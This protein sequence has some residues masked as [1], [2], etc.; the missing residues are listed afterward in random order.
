MNF[1]FITKE[2]CL[3]FIAFYILSFSLTAQVKKEPRQPYNTVSSIYDSCQI[4]CN[5]FP[6][7][8]DNLVATERFVFPAITNNQECFEV[9]AEFN[10][11]C[12]LSFN[13]SKWFLIKIVKGDS[14]TFS[15]DNSNNYD[16]DAA[17]WGPIANNDLDSTCLATTKFPVT[18]DYSVIKPRFKL[19]NPLI[20]GYYI[21]V[22]SNYSN[23]NTD[24]LLNQP[25]GGKVIYSYFCSENSTI[26]ANISGKQNIQAIS[27]LKLSFE[28]SSSSYIS[29]I[30][31]NSIELLPGFETDSNTVFNASIGDCINTS[32]NYNPT[33]SN[34]ICEDFTNHKALIPHLYA[35]SAMNELVGTVFAKSQPEYMAYDNIYKKMTKI[36]IDKRNDRFYWAYREPFV[37]PANVKLRTN[38]GCPIYSDVRS[39]N[40]ATT[41][42][43]EV[44]LPNLD[45]VTNYFNLNTPFSCSQDLPYGAST[46]DLWSF[47]MSDSIPYIYYRINGGEWKN[48]VQ[49]YKVPDPFSDR[50]LEVSMI[51]QIR[52]PKDFIMDFSTDY[53]T[54]ID[55]YIVTR[56][57]TGGH[58]TGTAVFNRIADSTVIVS[59]SQGHIDV[60]MQLGDFPAYG[61]FGNTFHLGKMAEGDYTF[62]LKSIK[63]D[64]VLDEELFVRV[65]F[66]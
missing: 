43:Y 6:A 29:T 40:I 60:D 47:Y 41:S 8:R 30:G 21:L 13:N 27:K 56:S 26:H 55:R 1:S 45:P 16:I 20:G 4:V 24:I 2:N 38:S 3:V 52:V 42:E 32:Q 64:F 33:S 51:Y 35:N 37:A 10:P 19:F 66:K 63:G 36:G 17:I 44:N 46:F 53:G 12:L 9:P 49:H 57:S 54:T 61:G 5:L 25:I 31:G 11:G 65:K 62:P 48:N 34:V 7:N 18:C 15:F 23:D 14:L 59:T 28:I 39:S 22:I 58:F 50:Y